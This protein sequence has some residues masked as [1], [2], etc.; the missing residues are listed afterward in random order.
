[1]TQ[2]LIWPREMFVG[3]DAE[4]RLIGAGAVPPVV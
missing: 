4:N 3:Q 1:V 2:P